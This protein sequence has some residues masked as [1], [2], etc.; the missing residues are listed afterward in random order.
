MS[1]ILPFDKIAN[2]RDFGSY[3]AKDGARLAHGKLFRAGHLN[4][5]S[6]ADLIS[7]R[8]LNIGLIVDLRY[9]SERERQPN[10]WPKGM[11]T[12]TLA[13][14]VRRSGRAP[15]EAFIEHDLHAPEDAKR[16]MMESYRARPDMEGFKSIFK[17]T[18]GHMADTGDSVLIHCAA[19]KDRTGTLVALIQALLGVSF[20]NIMKD[21]LLTLQAVNIDGLLAPAAAKIGARFGRVYDPESLR[22]MFAVY[23]AYLEASLTAMG[24]PIV[25]ACDKL[26][27]N[28]KD[29]MRL[30]AHYVI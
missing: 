3:C 29:I 20:E 16:Y 23:E 21:Y 11:G 7:L 1:R 18:L 17:A 12:Q 6:D 9:L 10:R 13:F 24:D 15:H 14:D 8:A 26:G 2:A 5:A 30:K 28:Q 22:P 27:F 4:A 25:Y 19:G